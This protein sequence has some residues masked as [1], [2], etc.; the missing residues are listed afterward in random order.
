M[1]G[2][3]VHS[4]NFLQ[5]KCVVLVMTVIVFVQICIDLFYIDDKLKKDIR[6]LFKPKLVPVK[7]ILIWNSEFRYESASDFGTGPEAFVKNE[8]PV[9]QCQLIY[10]KRD[11]MFNQS[12]MSFDQF[13]AVVINMLEVDDNTTTELDKFVRSGHQRF[14]FLTQES[15]QTIFLDSSK[16]NNYF[17]WTMSYRL[18]SD[19]RLLY[20]RVRRKDSAPASRSEAR[21]MIKET[22]QRSRNFLRGRNRSVAWMASHCETNSKREA[23]VTELRKYIDVDVFGECGKYKC[24]RNGTHW[25]SDPRCYDFLAANYKFYLSFENSICSDYVTEKFFEILAHDMVPVVYGGAD[26]SAIAPMKSYIDALQFTPQQLA[27]YLH[28]V[29]SN[30]TLYNEFF[31]WKEHYTVEAGME[32]MVRRAYCDL[33]R[34]LH[35]DSSVKVYDDMGTFWNFAQC[36]SPE[37]LG[38]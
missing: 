34:K 31:W 11:D 30:N 21:Q 18:E 27:L 15:P 5:R 1:T 28:N 23:Y 14:V 25:I 4:A 3:G 7:T 20:G 17:N 8:C 13:D 12:G 10:N 24:R 19:I 32:Q 22:H 6:D 29:G 26:Y 33:C 37:T 9:T 38:I 16:W 35:E 36:T 2:T